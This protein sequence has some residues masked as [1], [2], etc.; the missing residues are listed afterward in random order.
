MLE[1]SLSLAGPKLYL[2]QKIN[3]RSLIYYH[4]FKSNSYFHEKFV[5]IPETVKVGEDVD[6]HNGHITLLHF[7]LIKIRSGEGETST[8]YSR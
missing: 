1:K 7:K 3:W 8:P 4:I 2:V 6:I 5:I